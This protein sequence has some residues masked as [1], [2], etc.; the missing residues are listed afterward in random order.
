MKKIDVDDLFGDDFSLG[1]KQNLLQ[2]IVFIVF[3]V[4]VLFF[5]QLLVAFAA[6]LFIFTGV[7]GLITAA[8]MRQRCNRYA[9]VRKGCVDIC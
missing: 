6:I 5:P 7:S 8:V 4:M 9:E 1:W 2:G 3:G